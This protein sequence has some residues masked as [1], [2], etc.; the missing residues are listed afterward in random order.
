MNNNTIIEN[1]AKNDY[2]VQLYRSFAEILY[3]PCN[4]QKSYLHFKYNICQVKPQSLKVSISFWLVF[5]VLY[6]RLLSIRHDQCGPCHI[7]N[8]FCEPNDALYCYI[9][10]QFNR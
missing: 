10:Y 6:L 7:A 1:T 2:T 8:L 4:L 3:M 5:S 9:W